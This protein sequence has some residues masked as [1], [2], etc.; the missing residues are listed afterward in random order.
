MEHGFLKAPWEVM[1]RNF[2]AGH[3]PIA[4]EV[5]QFSAILN[6][7][8]HHMSTPQSMDCD[9]VP[10]AINPSTIQTLR[11]QLT[12][13]K[14]KIDQSRATDEHSILRCY[15]RIAHLRARASG[16]DPPPATA[17][18]SDETQHMDIDT[19][20]PPTAPPLTP[21]TNPE[22]PIPDANS[23]ADPNGNEHK[24]G[25]PGSTAPNDHP[26]SPTV[27]GDENGNTASDT[28]L[29]WEKCRLDRA[30][31][32]Y[33]LRE[34]MYDTAHMLCRSHGFEHIVDIDI[35]EESRGVIEALRRHDCTEALKW[36]AEN[37]RRLQKVSSRLEFR[38]RLQEFVELARA[39]RKLDAITYMR[40]YISAGCDAERQIDIQRFMA[41]LAYDSSTACEPYMDM[42]GEHKW[43]ELEVAFKDDDYRLHGLTRDSTIEILLKAGLSSLKTRKCGKDPGRNPTCPTCV[44]PYLS[45]AHRLPRSR[46]ENSVLVCSISGQIMD[47]NNP[48]MA[49]PNGNVYSYAALRALADENDGIVKDPQSGDEANFSDLRK[50]FIM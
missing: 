28:H 42:Y 9:G 35:F 44:E 24:A 31:A 33:M 34:G 17:H 49:M 1:L 39:R 29:R 19:P 47:E 23:S 6:R 13:I 3:K 43:L 50:C 12:G 26:A 14:R 20:V 41:L 5:E 21:T 11:A 36:C 48:P 8:I 2:R 45:L 32:D 37:K 18:P 27:E 22:Q 30:L 46:H 40:K 7:L 16:G 15:H 25:S 38:L 10:T 4:K